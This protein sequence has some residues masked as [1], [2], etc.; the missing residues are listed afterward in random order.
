MV[1]IASRVFSAYGAIGEASC[2]ECLTVDLRFD[3]ESAGR[4]MSRAGSVVWLVACCL[5]APCD[6]GGSPP[7]FLRVAGDARR[8]LVF[9]VHLG[10]AG[11]R[12][13]L[14]CF[15]C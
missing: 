7:V 14:H 15:F 8:A 5:Y 4:M 10:L 6:S 1:I 9:G 3:V 2:E 13:A 12:R 11:I